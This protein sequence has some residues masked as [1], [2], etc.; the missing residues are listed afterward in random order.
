M[1]TRINV[2]MVIY[3]IIPLDIYCSI[4]LVE[5]GRGGGDLREWEIEGLSTWSGNFGEVAP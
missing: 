2:N 3:S 5:E 4:C 1:K